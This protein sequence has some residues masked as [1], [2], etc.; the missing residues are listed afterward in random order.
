MK[1]PLNHWYAV[2]EPREVGRKPLTVERFGQRLVF[3]R[4]RDGQLHAQLDRCPHLGASLGGG[5]VLDDTLVCPFHGFR[6][7]AAGR[8]QHAPALG[9]KA[10]PPKGLVV[11]TFKLRE[12]HD[13]VWLW[14][15]DPAL[16]EPELPFFTA[17]QQPWH[18]YTVSTEWPVHY[19]R[20]I[21][22]QLDVAHLPFVHR[23]TIGAG[24]RTLVEG[25]YVEADLQGI[26]VWVN[27]WVDDG[28]PLRSQTQLAEASKGSEAG[29]DLRFPNC[30]LLNISP[31]FKN[32]LAFVPVNDQCTRY[33]LRSYFRFGP[34]W[35]ARPLGWL[36]S[37]SNR[38]ILGQDRRV[39]ITQT[40]R[41]S[42][43]ARNDQLIGADRAI[44][45]FRRFHS[46]LLQRSTSALSPSSPQAISDTDPE[47]PTQG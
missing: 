11:Q 13:L 47:H 14:W 32:F 4:S 12:A 27:N 25:P 5:T 23:S 7:D 33:Y 24:G 42:G 3:W 19:T 20:A 36:I 2:L 16:A 34:R 26:R 28:R 30:W 17:L 38:Y 9:H 15:G 39:V 29:L 1:V 45:Q 44:A 10:T 37:L 18:H 6:F 8:C 46:L 35:L 31:S 41:D 21:E 40:P 22:N 43:E